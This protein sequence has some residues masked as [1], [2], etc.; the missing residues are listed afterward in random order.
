M[1]EEADE[2]GPVPSVSPS[3]FGGRGERGSDPG[4]GATA[5]ALSALP[6]LGRHDPPVDPDGVPGLD[7]PALLS[8]GLGGVLP[9]G[10]GG[11]AVPLALALLRPD[12][13]RWMGPERVGALAAR[14]AMPEEELVALLE[15]PPLPPVGLGDPAQWSG[16]QVPLLLPGGGLA[17]MA[18]FWRPDRGRLRDRHALAARLVL[19]V[20]GRVDLRARLEDGRL[21]AVM[22]TANPLPRGTV[23]DLEEALAAVLHRLRLQGSLVVRHTEQDRRT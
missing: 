3:D 4:Y 23:V 22:E 6:P 7:G 12:V 20:T 18:L 2:L 13:R 14:L 16:R 5:R 17:W 21:D 8:A 10:L 11:L 1:T 19:P 9:G 15:A